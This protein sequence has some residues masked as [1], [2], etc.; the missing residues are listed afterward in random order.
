MPS[1]R[2]TLTSMPTLAVLV[3]V[4]VLRETPWVM[5][6]LTA[7]VVRPDVAMRCS[8]SLA[9]TRASMTRFV[10]SQGVCSSPQSSPQPATSTS[11]ARPWLR[12]A[13]AMMLVPT[14]AALFSARISRDCVT[15]CARVLACST[16]GG[17]SREN[18]D[19]TEFSAPKASGV[20]RL[21]RVPSTAAKLSPST[22][23]S[24]RLS[25]CLRPASS[26][27]SRRRLPQSSGNT[28]LPRALTRFM[29]PKT[30]SVEP[31]LTRLVTSM[32]LA[33]S[34]TSCVKTASRS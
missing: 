26:L 5:G 33:A 7:V 32:P 21:A 10:L 6:T 27:L 20:L 17:L 34:K 11:L 22:A 3:A 8:K 24:P 4:R 31:E 25:R 2:I 30:E 23:E 15:T 1:R 13:G 18:V 29:P 12:T 19:W 16:A 9:L 28:P 14:S